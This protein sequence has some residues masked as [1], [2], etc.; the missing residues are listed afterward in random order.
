MA[1]TTNVGSSATHPLDFNTVQEAVKIHYKPQRVRNMVYKDNPFLGIIPKYTKF[2]GLSMPI[3]LRFSDPQRRAA[4]FATG[5]ANTSTSSL[6]QFS[7]TRAKDYGFAFIDGETIQATKGD[8]NAFLRYLTM[9]IDG[10]I[11]SI[12]RSLAVSLYRDGSGSIGTIHATDGGEGQADPGGAKK[13][14]LAN[15]EDIT[16]FEVGMSIVFAPNSGS[17]SGSLV[18]DAVTIE[19]VD[20]TRGA[21]TVSA[22]LH[23]DVD[24]SDLI[25]QEGDYVTKG[26]RLK[27]RGLDAWVPAVAPTSDAFFG[28]DRTSDSTR[29]GGLRHDASGDPVEEAIIE[30]AAMIARDGGRPDVALCDYATYALIE[31]AMQSRVVYNTIK[32]ADVDI[33]FSGISIVGPT[34]PITIVPDYN[35]QPNTLWLLQK[36]TWVLATLGDAPQFLDLDSLR[37][38]RDAGSDAYEV[39]LGYYGQVGCYAPGWNCRITL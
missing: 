38:L 35:C 18:G 29:L 20:R 3:P 2:G 4:T 30:A 21:M 8:N 36:D 27:V 25:F 7:L 22:N 13:I 15:A 33:G 28:V 17:T 19:T 6:A 23:A 37:M 24:A 31:K 10:A 1:H 34:G 14:K 16:N 11:N 39:R 5:Q 26:D 32:A 9:E 12:T